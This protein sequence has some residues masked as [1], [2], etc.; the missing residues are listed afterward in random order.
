MTKLLQAWL[1]L[2]AVGSWVGAHSN[3]LS[4]AGRA[5]YMMALALGWTHLTEMQIGAI[6]LFAEAILGLF[7]ESTTVAKARVGERIDAEVERRTGTGDVSDS[8]A[9]A[10]SGGGSGG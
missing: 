6:G 7:I 9:R 3:K 4:S 2:Q 1:V 8:A 10:L 5:G